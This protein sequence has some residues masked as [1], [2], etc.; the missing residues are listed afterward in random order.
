MGQKLLGYTGMS[1][2]ARARADRLA[3]QRGGINNAKFT[4]KLTENQ[5]REVRT[6]RAVG[7]SCKSIAA[8]FSVSHGVIYGI[9][10]G[11]TY[12]DVI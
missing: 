8:D 9:S 5:V 10:I 11:R 3:G 7:E 1:R 2:T 12:K 6:R 4:R